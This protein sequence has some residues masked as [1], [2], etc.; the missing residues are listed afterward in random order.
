MVG[1]EVLS[2]HMVCRYLLKGA[3]KMMATKPCCGWNVAS[4]DS[5]R[6]VIMS[7]GD[8]DVL[9]PHARRNLMTYEEHVFPYHHEYSAKA[10]TFFW[11][12]EIV[13]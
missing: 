11:E 7:D 5:K 6:K 1:I 13:T 12:E 9:V 4:N 3:V 10:A 8:D 2:Y